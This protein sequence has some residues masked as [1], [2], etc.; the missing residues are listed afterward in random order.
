MSTHDVLTCEAVPCQACVDHWMEVA[1]QSNGLARG[2]EAHGAQLDA[3]SLW[4][5]GREA[6]AKAREKRGH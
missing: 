4:Q 1:R 5:S 6:E 3:D 2:A